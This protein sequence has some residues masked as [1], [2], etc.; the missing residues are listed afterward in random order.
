MNRCHR[1][2][3]RVELARKMCKIMYGVR[4]AQGITQVA[5]A[6]V[7][8]VSQSLWSKIEAEQLEPT[9]TVWLE[10]CRV[11]NI[12]AELP[13]RESL[14][15]L[16]VRKQRKSHEKPLIQLLMTEENSEEF[17]STESSEEETQE[18]A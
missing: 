17:P 9:A 5:M 18:A 15:D 11:T 12:S 10:F 1:S 14:P 3:S 16:P 7:M 6:K 4:K 2:A 8:G 13:Y